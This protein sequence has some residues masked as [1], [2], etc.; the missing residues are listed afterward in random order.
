MLIGRP[1][2][3]GRATKFPGWFGDGRPN[4][5]YTKICSTHVSEF[6]QCGVYQTSF[7]LTTDSTNCYLSQLAAHIKC[8][9]HLFLQAFLPVCTS[10]I[11]PCLTFD[12]SCTYRYHMYKSQQIVCHHVSVLVS[13]AQPTLE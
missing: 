6:A 5:I 3:T 8:P 1:W 4:G 2:Q 12:I 13:R 10:A 11:Y 7:H 9:E